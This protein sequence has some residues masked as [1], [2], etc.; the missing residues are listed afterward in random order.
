MTPTAEDSQ[1][2]DLWWGGP[3]GWSMAPSFAVCV[4]LTLAIIGAAIFI[5]CEGMVGEALA[6]YEVYL[7]AGTVWLIQLTRWGYR[8][9]CYGYRLTTRRLFVSRGFWFPPDIAIDV[10][11]LREVR[12]RQTPVERW[13]GVGR[14]HMSAKAPSHVILEGVSEPR[15]IAGLIEGVARGVAK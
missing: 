10:G 9:T 13:L 15:R 14:I 1:E 5:Y 12:V 11:D 7:L 4:V 6:R 2:V 3:S 8:V